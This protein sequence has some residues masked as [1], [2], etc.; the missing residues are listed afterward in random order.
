MKIEEDRIFGILLFHEGCNSTG[1]TPNSQAAVFTFGHGDGNAIK[2]LL[3]IG[4]KCKTI[5]LHMKH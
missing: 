3:I 2:P 5:V 4:K 1:T